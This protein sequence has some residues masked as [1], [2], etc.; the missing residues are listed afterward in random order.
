MDVGSFL[1]SDTQSPKLI[2]PSEASFDYPAP[3]A[4]STAMLG[5]TLCKQRHNMPIS[6]T[7]ADRFRVISTITQYA[8]RAVARATAHSLQ[9]WDSIDEPQRFLRIVSVGAG[10]M[11]DERNALTIADQMTLATRF[12]SISGI[13]TGLRPPQNCPN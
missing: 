7:Q 5:V 12:G 6:Q 10:E 1:V 2:E 8:I 11:D 4:Q 13:R 3:S 9:R